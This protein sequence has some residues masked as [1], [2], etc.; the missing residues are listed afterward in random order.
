M[1]YIKHIAHVERVLAEDV[2]TWDYSAKMLYMHSCE[3]ASMQ[4]SCEYVMHS[5]WQCRRSVSGGGGGGGGK[6]EPQICI[7][8]TVIACL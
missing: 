4:Y 6:S 3:H 7:N 5:L 8:I 1:R 2:M